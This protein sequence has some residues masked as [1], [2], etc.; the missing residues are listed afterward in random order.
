MGRGSHWI[1]LSNIGCSENTWNVYNSLQPSKKDLRKPCENLL[2]VF[3]QI[4]PDNDA[5]FIINND[6]QQQRDPINCGLFAIANVL[7]LVMGED[8]CAKTYKIKDDDGTD[9]MRKH[10]RKCLDDAKDDPEGEILAF[11]SIERQVRRPPK[12]ECLILNE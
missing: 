1:A 8:P 4:L 7:T 12:A 10:Y 3:K 11:P 2:L 6:V 5:V 9:M